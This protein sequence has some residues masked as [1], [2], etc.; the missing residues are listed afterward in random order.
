[1]GNTEA[2]QQNADEV[3]RIMCERG[4]ETASDSNLK[5]KS[6]RIDFGIISKALIA[7]LIIGAL[8]F[9]VLAITNSS[10][11]QREEKDSSNN[12]YVEQNA[13]DVDGT[14]NEAA[15][16]ESTKD[17]ASVTSTGASQADASSP[18]SS[19]YQPSVPSTSQ[20]IDNSY[21]A[22]DCSA[23]E[24]EVEIRKILMEREEQQYNDIFNNRKSYSELADQAGDNLM[25]ANILYTEQKARI[26]AAWQVY[27]DAQAAY[28]LS[29]DSMLNCERQ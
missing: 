5:K 3:H 1:M 7:V 16:T 25:Q 24:R 20:N 14:E 27:Q 18:Q 13:D 9:G 23:E 22:P 26:D 28:Q 19:V 10:K 29:Y 15:N 12:T 8:S 17:T 4:F 11:N 6:R 2:Q 21:S